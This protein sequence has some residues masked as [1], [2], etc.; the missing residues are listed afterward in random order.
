MLQIEKSRGFK[1]GKYGGQS[2]RVQNS[3]KSCW[4]DLACGQELN[5]PKDIF[6][7]RIC[8]RGPHAVS[9]ALGRHQH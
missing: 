3:A 1:S 9:K 8:P 5:L 2:A 6:S 7:V 4:V